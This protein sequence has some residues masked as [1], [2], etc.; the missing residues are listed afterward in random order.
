MSPNPFSIAVD[1]GASKKLSAKDYLMQI[2]G[3]T[4]EEADAILASLSNPIPG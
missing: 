2:E 1:A 4:S 3:K